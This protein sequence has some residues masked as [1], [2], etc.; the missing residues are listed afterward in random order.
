LKRL[1]FQSDLEAYRQEEQNPH[2]LEKD[3]GGVTG[4]GGL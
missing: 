1:Y 4:F 3:V 2:P